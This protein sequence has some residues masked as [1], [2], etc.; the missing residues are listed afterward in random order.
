M[1]YGDLILLYMQVTYPRAV[2]SSRALLQAFRSFRRAISTPLPLSAIGG[3]DERAGPPPTA[4]DPWFV[5]LQQVPPL[6]EVSVA[7][8]TLLCDMHWSNL[9]LR[10]KTPDCCCTS[11]AGSSS[12][13]I[14]YY[15]VVVSTAAASR[16][17]AQGVP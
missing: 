3:P 14:L 2:C 8:P 16:G 17:H 6:R 15:T 11:T 10:H 1:L 13:T 7:I 5:A 4:T 12:S 9:S